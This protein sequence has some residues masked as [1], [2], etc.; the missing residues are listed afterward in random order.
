EIWIQPSCFTARELLHVIR[1]VTYLTNPNRGT[2]FRAPPRARPC[3]QRPR[4]TDL[5][6]NIHQTRS[7]S[8]SHGGLAMAMMSARYPSP[9]ALPPTNFQQLCRSVALPP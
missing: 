2:P 1:Y 9:T 6:S 5:L 7:P 4:P 8:R 3:H